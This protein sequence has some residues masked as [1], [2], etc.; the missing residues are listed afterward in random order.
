MFDSKSELKQLLHTKQKYRALGS[1]FILKVQNCSCPM[2]NTNTTIFWMN[3]VCCCCFFFTLCCPL[4]FSKGEFKLEL[5]LANILSSRGLQ[6]LTQQNEGETE[7]RGQPWLLISCQV[8]LP[9]RAEPCF[10]LSVPLSA[11]PSLDP[12]TQG[13]RK[14]HV[15]A[16]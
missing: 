5:K 9:C 3:R 4:F 11:V 7:T 15:S 2:L 16:Y 6:T 12:L 1:I 8:L 10:H 14:C 13:S